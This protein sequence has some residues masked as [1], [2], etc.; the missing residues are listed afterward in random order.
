MH[1]WAERYDRT[2]DDLFAVQEQ[3]AQQIVSTLVGRIQDDRLQQ[4]LRKP[5]VSLAAYDCLLRGLAH[6]RGYAEDDNQ[7]AYDLFARAIEL[8]PNYALAHAYLA[9]AY[10][11]LNGSASVSSE[12]LEAAFAMA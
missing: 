6:F 3:V 10:L 1:V 7:K 9:N 8:D 5:T 2:L 11:V 12:V 4:S